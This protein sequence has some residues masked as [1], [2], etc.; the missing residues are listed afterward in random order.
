LS[1][2]KP[3][4]IEIEVLLWSALAN[5]SLGAFQRMF[6]RRASLFNNPIRVQA[7]R[8]GMNTDLRR[9]RVFFGRHHMP[10]PRPCNDSR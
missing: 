7:V 5:V 8:S 2:C 9:R 10:V 3:R 6:L 1:L 4:R